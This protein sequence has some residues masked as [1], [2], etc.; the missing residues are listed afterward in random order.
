MSRLD[1]WNK[2]RT[3]VRMPKP[4]EL[5]LM[6]MRSMRC[7]KIKRN[8]VYVEI[9][10]EKLWYMDLQQTVDNLQKK[11]YVRYDPADLRSVRLYD[12]DDRYLF[13]WQSAD[14]LLVDY[15]TGIKE[16]I[17]DGEKSSERSESLLRNRL[18][19]YLQTLLMTRESLCLI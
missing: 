6:M 16:E 12:E 14:A 18:K 1:V 2:T 19:E 4:E 13:T 9:F 11:V 7:Q 8:G 15:I 10:G 5:N 3:S 17:A